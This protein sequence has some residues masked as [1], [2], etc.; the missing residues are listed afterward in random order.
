MV[1][2]TQKG[3]QMAIV[4][5]IP[6]EGIGVQGHTLKALGGIGG[7]HIGSHLAYFFLN[8]VYIGFLLLAD[9]DL[10]MSGVRRSN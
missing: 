6:K 9:R 1:D 3:A 10:F 2:V 8:Y 4:I 7:V 5:F